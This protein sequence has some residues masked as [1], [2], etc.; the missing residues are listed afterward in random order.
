LLLG[1]ASLEERAGQLA[2]F[3]LAA[4]SHAGGPLAVK[5]GRA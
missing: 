1:D 2:A 5:E 3:V 4:V